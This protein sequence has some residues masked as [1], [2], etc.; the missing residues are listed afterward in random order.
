MLC[1][2]KVGEIMEEQW[3]YKTD[4]QIHPPTKK[5]SSTPD[6][7]GVD[8]EDDSGAIHS[9]KY[10]YKITKEDG[11]QGNAYYRNLP[12]GQKRKN[13]QMIKG[14][15]KGVHYTT[16]D[17]RVVVPVLIVLGLLMTAVCVFLTIKFPLL[18]ILFDVFWFVVLIS[19]IRPR[20]I[21]KWRNQAKRHKEQKEND[22]CRQ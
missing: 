15:Q 20:H 22:I 3:T 6:P 8:W 11:W 21:R 19:N 16:D 14:T 9:F 2:S 4:D 7:E 18:G 12:V 10:T 1:V 13:P 5:Q 17:Y